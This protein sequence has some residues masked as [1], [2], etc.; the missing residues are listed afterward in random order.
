[1][2]EGTRVRFW[3]VTPEGELERLEGEV[4][5][6]EEHESILIQHLPVI[7]GREFLG[8]VFGI[9]KA[10]AREREKLM[11]TRATSLG[12]S[13]RDYLA[14]TAIKDTNELRKIEVV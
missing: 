6:N 9:S 12:V 13:F 8:A 4:I 2:K 11:R 7:R 14:T 5:L 10:R 1:M 3:N